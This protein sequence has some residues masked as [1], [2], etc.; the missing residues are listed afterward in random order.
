MAEPTSLL[1][2]DTGEPGF[3][4]YIH[5]P[6]CA[7]KC[8]YCDFNSHVRHQKIDQPRFTQA[9]LKEMETV[10]ALSGPKTVT[11]IFLGGGTPSLMDPA[12]VGAILDG[13]AKHWTVPRGIEITM[14]ANPT[15]VEAERFR[16]YRSAGVNRVSLGVQALNDADLKFL[17]R[18]HS[19]EDA[20]KAV[21]LAREIFPRMSFDLIYARPG[22][23]IAAWEAELKQAISYAVDHLSLYQLTIEEGTP[24]FGL[25][26]AGKIVTPDEEHAAQLYEATQEITAREGLP[27][28]EVSNHARPGAESRHNLTYWRYGDYAGIGPGAHGR[29]SQGHEKLATA[30]EKHPETWLTAV[31]ANGHGMVDQ[32]SL[33]PEEQSDELLLMGL[34]LREGVDLAR[35]QMLS[36]RDPDPAREEFLLGHGFIERL[37]NSRLRCTPKGM[38]VLDAVVADLA[39]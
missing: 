20:L 17:G 12:T 4:V 30:T 38:L 16:G 28:Y 37:G 22:Q 34:R 8:P 3:G 13:I 27:A 19:V 32:E 11:S 18:L 1:L 5:W 39:C 36:G 25:H 15:S 10:R 33:G 6:F 24:F 14:E 29:L 7:A 31:E 26:K 35:W 21:R 9:F 23:T 2:P